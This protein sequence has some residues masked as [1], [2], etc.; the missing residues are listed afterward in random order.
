MKVLALD[1]TTREGSVALVED[2]RVVDERTG[3][4]SRTHAERLPGEIVA[5]ADAHHLALSAVDLFAVASG[6][7]SFTG[8]RIGIATMQGLAFVHRRPLS[9]IG[10]LDALAQLGSRGA[11]SGATV[12]AWMDAHR[13]QVFAALYRVEDAPL[14]D[15][16][17]L[18]ELEG[19]TVGAPDATLARW[20]STV[21]DGMVF[22][23]DGAVMY[24]DMIARTV[25][26][27]KTLAP[28]ALAG[29]IARLAASRAARGDAA[30]PA[31]I[32]PLYVRR[33]D[34]EIARDEKLR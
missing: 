21:T 24:A 8:L 9:G 31:R 10:A 4:A 28:P 13:R 3:D 23:G 33:S 6:P 1:T 20:R 11:P 16:A 7:G 5:L 19:P 17:R 27:A 22:V 15:R 32:Q 26:S 25:P 29:A 30:G 18:V 14:F 12:A 2:D 34:A